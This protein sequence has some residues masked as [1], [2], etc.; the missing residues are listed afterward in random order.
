[1]VVSFPLAGA[2]D[3]ALIPLV[4]GVLLIMTTAAFVAV[5]FRARISPPPPSSAESLVTRIARL[6][7]VRSGRQLPPGEERQYQNERAALKQELT[8]ALRREGS[9]DGL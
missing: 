9:R 4:L 6:D 1:V 3:N 8:E 7:T 5:R 2:R